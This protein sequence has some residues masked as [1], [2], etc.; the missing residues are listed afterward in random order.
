[1]TNIEKKQLKLP[2]YDQVSHVFRTDE[3]FQTCQLTT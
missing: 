1:L 3:Q 2:F